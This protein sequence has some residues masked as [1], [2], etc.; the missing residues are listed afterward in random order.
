MTGQ[1]YRIFVIG[2]NVK[3]CG[4][5]ACDLLNVSSSFRTFVKTE[6]CEIFLRTALNTA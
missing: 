5:L 6:K 2:V 3:Q 1:E 4:K